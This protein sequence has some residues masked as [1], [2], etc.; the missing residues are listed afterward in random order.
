MVN[1]KGEDDNDE[2]VL[3]DTSDDLSEESFLSEKEL[4]LL[5]SKDLKSDVM[6]DKHDWALHAEQDRSGKPLGPY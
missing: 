4:M 6:E 1:N 2:G 5:L 3:H